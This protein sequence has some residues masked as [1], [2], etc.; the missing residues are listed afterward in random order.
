MR[1]ICYAYYCSN[2]IGKLSIVYVYS[3]FNQYFKFLLFFAMDLTHYERLNIRK[4]KKMTSIGHKPRRLVLYPKYNHFI[5]RIIDGGTLQQNFDKIFF[6][7]DEFKITSDEFC[8]AFIIPPE[9]DVVSHVRYIYNLALKEFP[10]IQQNPL[11]TKFFV[12]IWFQPRINNKLCAYMIDMNFAPSS[13]ISTFP[14]KEFPTE[15]ATPCPFLEVY[16]LEID[17]T[18]LDDD[19]MTI[20]SKYSYVRGWAMKDLTVVSEMRQSLDSIRLHNGFRSITAIG[21]LSTAI[22]K[23]LNQPSPENPT[24]LILIDRSVDLLTPTITQMNYEGIIAEFFGIDCGLVKIQDEKGNPQLQLL[25]SKEDDLFKTIRSMNLQ[26]ASAEITRR[27]KEVSDTFSH[28]ASSGSLEE[29]LQKFRETAK[30]SVANK[31]LIDHLNLTN[32][33]IEQMDHSKYFRR[34]MNEEANALS[35]AS[36]MK[37]MLTEML[38]SGEDFIQIIRILSLESLLK[39]GYDQKEYAKLVNQ[40][41]FNYGFQ[42]S[43]YLIRLFECGIFTQQASNSFK[44]SKFVKDFKLYLPDFDQLDPPPQEAFPYLGYVP[45]SIRFIQKVLNG[46]FASVAKALSEIKQESYDIGNETAGSRKSGNILVCYL[47]GTTHSELNSLRR[48]E[49]HDPEYQ[50]VS[51]QLLTTSMISANEFFENM[52]YLIPGWSSK[53]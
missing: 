22:A 40:I 39:G 46:E 12:E 45:L 50:N 51:F 26:E 53:V 47:G 15:D 14:S 37:S 33:S 25:S 1:R 52:S 13:I 8:Y 32:K 23:S 41:C 31:T 20:E 49:L 11:A 3:N 42:M 27:T 48:L 38:E 24:Q 21:T 9:I 44:W 18:P 16:P 10:K 34:I 5:S 7:N 2:T 19:V 28:K 29:G 43:L 4:F 30:V 36:S 35:G 6:F 17:V